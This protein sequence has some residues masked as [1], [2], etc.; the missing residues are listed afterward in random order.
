MQTFV[1][2]DSRF[3]NTEAVARAIARGATQASSVTI[4]DTQAAKL[5][6]SSTQPDLVI[7]GGP[8][9]NHGP[10]DGLKA[11]A[12]LVARRFARAT[13]ACF[14]TRYRGPVLIMGSGAAATAK[15]LAKAGT[16]LVAQPESFFIL[17][18]GSVAT[19]T[20]EPG[21]IERAESWGR[22]VVAAAAASVGTVAR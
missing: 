4:L 3:G 17:R 13:A 11:L 8:T 10:S 2:Y 22:D 14:D 21:E 15:S 20:L 9:H 19:Q 12:D 1:I 5:E 6:A 18:R 16:A 7:V